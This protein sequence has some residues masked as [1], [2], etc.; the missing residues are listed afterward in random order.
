MGMKFGSTIAQAALI[1]VGGLGMA[2]CGSGEVDMWEGGAETS[3]DLTGTVREWA[4]NVSSSSANAG[5]VT[6][7]ITNEGTIGHEF[8]VVKTDI[9]DGE[10]PLDGDHFSEEAEGIEVIDEIGE[11]AKETTET[12]TVDLTAGKYQLV[13]NLPGHYDAGMHTSFTVK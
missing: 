10:I 13:C 1:S 6:F 8:L 2:A 4:V 11:Y 12:L 7:T 9:P 3:N 5:Q